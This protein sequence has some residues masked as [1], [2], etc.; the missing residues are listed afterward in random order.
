MLS[1]YGTLT[2]A[3]TPDTYISGESSTVAPLAARPIAR[4]TCRRTW[5]RNA[6]FLETLRLMLVHETRGPAGAPR[7]L[8]LAFSTPRPWLADGKTIRVQDAP[9]SFGPVSYSIE[10]HGPLVHV[11]VDIA[12]SPARVA[13]PP[14]AT[15]GR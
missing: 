10:R 1:L 6:T 5:A 3:M 15:A 9:T 13:S 4:C 7:G 14:A 8:E 11:T 12:A 2:A